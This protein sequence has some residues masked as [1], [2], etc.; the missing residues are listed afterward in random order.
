M[1]KIIL[2]LKTK[3]HS[4]ISAEGQTPFTANTMGLCRTSGHYRLCVNPKIDPNADNSQRI[5]NLT[6]IEYYVRVKYILTRRKIVIFSLLSYTIY[7]VNRIR[8]WETNI[9]VMRRLKFP[10]NHTS[11]TKHASEVLHRNTLLINYMYLN[12]RVRT[13]Y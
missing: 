5:G 12:K 1:I 9:K 11:H 7:F 3:E 2:E 10:P 4:P 13:I 8:I 6:N